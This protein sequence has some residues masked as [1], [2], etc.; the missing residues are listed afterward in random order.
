MPTPVPDSHQYL[1]PAII[2]IYR[3][4]DGEV[5]TLR[6]GVTQV[7]GLAMAFYAIATIPLIEKLDEDLLQLWYTDPL[8]ATSGNVLVDGLLILRYSQLNVTHRLL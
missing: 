3:I 5:I 8:R 7:G 6:G 1:L 4:D 2:P